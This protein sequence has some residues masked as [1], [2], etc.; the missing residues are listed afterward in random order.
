MDTLVFL[1]QGFSGANS[2]LKM[3]GLIILCALIIA[4]SYYTTK[5]VGRRQAGKL[6]GGNFRS[7]EIF[8]LA[9]NKYLQIIQVGKKYFL[10]A[11]SKDNVTSIAELSE[12]DLVL[13]REAKDA[14]GF[15]QI[16]SGIVKQR[17]KGSSPA[18]ITSKVTSGEDEGSD[19]KADVPETW[20]DETEQEETQ[21]NR[22][23]KVDDHEEAL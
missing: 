17:K 19:A 4:A 16:L 12:D 7:V 8:R 18:D 3:I 23:K 21:D 2:V 15:R 9:G 10:I 1:Y 6:E 14:P 13:V 11:V 20:F 22:I 5:F